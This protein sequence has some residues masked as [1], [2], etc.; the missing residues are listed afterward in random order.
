MSK[1]VFVDTNILL[2]PTFNFND[3]EKVYISIT[4]IEELDGLKKS[5]E[6]G[7]LAR[8]AIKNIENSK[9]KEIILYGSYSKID[10]LEHKNDN[11][12][13]GMA[14]TTYCS[15]ND[16]LFLTD[17]LNL[18]VKADS[19]GLPCERY[20]FKE[21]N[22]ELYKGYKEVSLSE[23]EMAVHYEC[24]VNKWGL[25]INEYLIIKNDDGEIVDRQCWTE[26]G[27]RPIN[28]KPFKSMYLGDIK[29]KDV[30]QQLAMDSLTNNQ[31][32]ILTGYAGSAKSL[33]SLAYIMQQLQN[34]KIN[35][36]VVV[37]N[38]VKLKNNE[39]LGYYSGNRTE[40]LLQNSIGGI[41]SSKLGDM[42]M[43]ETLIS[44][45]KLMIVPT[46]DIRG[47]E[48]SE[49]DCIFVTE[50]QNTDAYTMKTIIQRATEGCKVIVEG[51]VEEQQDIRH[52]SKKN[53]G[54]IRAINAFKGSELFACINLQNIYR[55]KLADIAQ[56]M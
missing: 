3:Y 47:I 6:V 39:Q 5:D 31:F 2:S 27:F 51:D 41:L 26:K 15:Y 9:N 50:A 11:T 38:P 55:S 56:N 10:F 17:D 33:L 16:L 37:F 36:C 46:S 42:I 48:I 8:Q 34:N 40:K 54:M 20:K 44:Q 53:N 22:F 32:T 4:T 52:C 43:V 29:P 12:I 25:N 13:L 45:G 18:K 19:I 35:K 30:Y 23:Y 49:R 28:G 21:E 14:Y 1:K 24:P 7:Y